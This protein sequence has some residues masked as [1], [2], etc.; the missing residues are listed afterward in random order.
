MVY[1]NQN[2]APW[3]GVDM[4][5][6]DFAAYGCAY[7]SVTMDLTYFGRTGADGDIIDPLDVYNDLGRACSFSW[8][9]AAS[10]YG[11]TLTTLPTNGTNSSFEALKAN[12]FD[13]VVNNNTPVVLFTNKLS[14]STKTH[15]LIVKG[16]YGTLPVD[17]DGNLVLSGITPSMILINDSLNASRTTLQQYLDYRGVDLNGKYTWG[18]R[19]LRIYTY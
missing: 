1:F 5:D 2:S 4:C 10:T 11:L 6:K 9:S 14:D 3:G 7:T 17:A 8:T 12:I 13:Y 18:V 15:Y 19:K 16:F